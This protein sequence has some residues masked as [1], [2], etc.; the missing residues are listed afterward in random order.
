MALGYGKVQTNA[1]CGKQESK[2][3]A[4]W[5]LSAKTTL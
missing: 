4:S 1:K 5:L 2:D 3:H